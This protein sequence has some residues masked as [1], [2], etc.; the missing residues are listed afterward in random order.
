MADSD[1]KKLPRDREQAIALKYFDPGSLPTILAKGHGEVAREIIK[2]AEQNGIPV[3]EDE[4]LSSLL[5][6]VQ[7]DEAI[8]EEAFRLVAEVICWLYFS[9]KD[10]REKHHSLK[11]VLESPGTNLESPVVPEVS[12]KTTK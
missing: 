4:T 2:L 6:K 9:D 7:T 12:K 11:A 10:W 8:P 3:T 1:K 5:S